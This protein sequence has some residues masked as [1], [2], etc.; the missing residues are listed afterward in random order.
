MK[1]KLSFLMLALVPLAAFGQNTQS[2]ASVRQS[3]YKATGAKVATMLKAPAAYCTPVLD[4]TDGDLITNVNFGGI[5]NTTAC[6]TN[7]FGD[8]TAMMTTTP[9]LPG[10]SYP[11]A[12]TV[13]AGFPNEQVSVWI[14]YNKNDT[15]DVGEFT[16]VG[17]VNTNTGGSLV[18]NGTIPIAAG[19]ATGSYRMRVRNAAIGSVSGTADLACDAAQIFG[20]TEDYTIKIGAATPPV[21]CLTAPNGLWPAA[22]FVPVCNGLPMPISTVCYAGEYSNVQV[23]TGTEYTFSLSKPD[24]YLTISDDAGTTVLGGAAGTLTWTS[25]L[26]GVVRFYSHTTVACG[27]GGSESVHTRFVKC[28]T[29]APPAVAC[30]DFKVLSN[31][32]ENGG[33]FG[34]ADAQRLAIDIPMGSSPFMIYG[35]EPTVIGAATT[36]TFNFYSD[37]AGIPGT[38][39]GSRVGTINGS[40]LTGN[41]FG[42]DFFKYTV[43]FNTP[44]NFAA[45]TKYWVEIVSD[46]VAWE[47][48]SVA[49]LGTKDAFLN[50]ATSG[51]WSI[52]TD[53]YVF[54]FLCTSLAVNDVKNNSVSVYPNPVKDILTINSKKT[55]ENVQVYNLAG[56]KMQ[57]S[58]KVIN[59]KLDMSKMAPGVYIISTI[60]EDGTNE[61]FKVIKK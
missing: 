48:S 33:F 7:G 1:S 3:T 43:S 14:D 15:F 34:G 40:T 41:A 54:N 4:C 60:L 39:L 9:I 32:L 49:N 10:M 38:L 42:Y 16:A 28:G 24:Y 45:N 55:I 36:F 57:V 11:I 35:M 51:A 52:G 20:E 17:N 23:I 61:S 19:T 18:V 58:S 26:T 8:Y 27:S 31:N 37:A 22:N 46:A 2:K 50:N 29:P 44:Y 30:A 25:T 21:G 56:Q 5:N 53:D 12:V 47:S 6:S 59:G 13:G